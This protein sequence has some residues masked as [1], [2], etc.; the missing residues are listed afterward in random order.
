MKKLLLALL[1]VSTSAFAEPVFLF[2]T[3]NY[4]PEYGECRLWN[5]SGKEVT[6]N[7]N[8]TSSTRMGSSIN[9]YQYVV[10]YQGM[11]AYQYARANNP[12]LDPIVYLNANAFCNTL[13]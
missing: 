2:P 10:L 1:L 7:F 3:C 4:Y 12:R 9:G 13:R 6:C 11:I 8:M 5:T